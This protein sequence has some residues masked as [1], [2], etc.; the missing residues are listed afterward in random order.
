MVIAAAVIAV[1]VAVW[2]VAFS[3]VLGV[4]TVAVRGAGFVTAAQIR[5]AAG[6][7][8]GTPLLRLDTAPI[9]RR[10]EALVGVRSA[11]VTKGYPNSVTITVTERVAVGFLDAGGGS[12]VLVD[13]GGVRFRTLTQRPPRLPLLVVPGGAQA[14]ASAA[15]VA[16]VAGDLPAAVLARVQSI[17]AFDPSA[18]TLLL[19]DSRVV[20]WGGVERSADKARVLPALLQ[21]PG[22][23]FD[24]S[25]PDAVIAR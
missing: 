3:P 7:K 1:L 15:A 16:T 9:V 24:V 6:V 17:Q 8:H 10:V 21:Q 20:R 4:R 5:S 13:A 22:T 18:I 25:D 14:T 19:T 2:I 23:Q 12:F 11:T